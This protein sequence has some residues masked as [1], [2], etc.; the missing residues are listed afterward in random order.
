MAALGAGTRV[1]WMFGIGT[2]IATE[3]GWA[4]IRT[5]WG[6]FA[7]WPVNVLERIDA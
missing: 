2:I 7:I 6:G 4:W 1:R 3:D 5:Q